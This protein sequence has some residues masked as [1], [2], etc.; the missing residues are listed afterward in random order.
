MKI[1]N[2]LIETICFLLVIIF[3]YAAFSKLLDLEQLRTT[4][5]ET[6]FLM[7]FT[8]WLPFVIIGSELAIATLLLSAKYRLT[9]LYASFILLFMFT[10]YIYLIRAFMKMV[11][12][13]CG[14]LIQKL[15]WS[16]HII[17]NLSLMAVTLAA[18]VLQSKH[19]RQKYLLQQ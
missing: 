18:I 13:S 3:A 9:A 19:S 2:T 12:C 7:L 11:P 16:Q 5:R 6:P 17:L 15:S 10:C 1:N 14:G 8:A 4:I